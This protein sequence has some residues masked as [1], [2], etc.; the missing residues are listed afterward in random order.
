MFSS[1][2]PL[3]GRF[4]WS[5]TLCGPRRSKAS[6]P[7]SVEVPRETSVNPYLCD[8]PHPSIKLSDSSGW[9]SA[10]R[11][12][13]GFRFFSLFRRHQWRSGAGF[14]VRPGERGCS[15]F[16][17]LSLP[18]IRSCREVTQRSDIG[19]VYLSRRQG[20]H[21]GVALP[22]TP[23]SKHKIALPGRSVTRRFPAMAFARKAEKDTVC[24]RVFP[25]L[26][27][28]MLWG[29]APTTTNLA[30]PWL[31][32]CPGPPG[33]R[34]P[35]PRNPATPQPTT[36]PPSRFPGTKKYLGRK[37]GIWYL[38]FGISGSVFRADLAPNFPF[39]P[40]M[41]DYNACVRDLCL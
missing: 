16:S 18:G 31:P 30:R 25:C 7:A 20:S 14:S 23:H 35:G 40:T 24:R 29:W 11:Q 3:N 33:P 26:P 37:V 19:R 36:P 10:Y 6:V 5:T 8:V 32:G 21:V 13:I 28:L 9:A 12:F 4:V 38:P 15:R 2:A 39:S 27:S 22:Q 1:N 34:A 17:A 41:Y